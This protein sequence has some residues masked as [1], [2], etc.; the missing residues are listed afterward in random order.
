MKIEIEER[1]ESKDEEKLKSL[2]SPDNGKKMEKS[3]LGLTVAVNNDLK[4]FSV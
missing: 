4:M 2:L 3:P 1:I